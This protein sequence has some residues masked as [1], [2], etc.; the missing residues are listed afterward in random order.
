MNKI[1][2]GK[3]VCYSGYRE[4]QSPA[5]GVFPTYQ[6]IKEDL[7]ILH[8]EFS[9]I[10]LYDPSQ[11]AKT[12]LEVIRNENLSLKVMLGID[13][14]GEISNPQCT[15]GG[16]YSE[17]QIID[18]IKTNEANLQEQIRLAKEYEDIIFAVSAGNE[19]VP[20]WNDNLVSPE[21]VLY[22]VNELKKNTSQL[23]T[24]CD[25]T[26]YWETILHEVANAVDLI[27]IH[28][29]PV[30]IGKDIEDGLSTSIDDFQRI[31]TKY[32]NTTCIITETGWP[33]KSNGRGIKIENATVQNQKRFI[34]EI[35]QWSE[36]NEILV[37]LF[38]AFDEPW[39]GAFDPEEPE[40]N[41]GIYTVSRTRKFQS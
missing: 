34:E 24:Y 13:L 29:Y 31:A 14:R 28:T 21:R 32:P 4:G 38:E 11:H 17:E 6:E 40:K 18:N 2:Y 33:T 16:V 27:S 39:K 15:W 30:W 5:T 12:V 26:D 3:A 19:A 20:E 37:F 36:E 1:N 22:F 9:Y 25:N 7:L 8:K 41:W 35:Q 23:V 10:R